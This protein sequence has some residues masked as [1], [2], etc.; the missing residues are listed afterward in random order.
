MGMLVTAVPGEM[1]HEAVVIQ[2]CERCNGLTAEGRNLG[3]ASKGKEWFLRSIYVRNEEEQ[4]S[5]KRI[6]HACTDGR[7]SLFRDHFVFL[8]TLQVSEDRFPLFYFYSCY[9]L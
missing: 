2:S 3:M 4:L 1:C 5:N 9:K 7:L 6:E 8:N